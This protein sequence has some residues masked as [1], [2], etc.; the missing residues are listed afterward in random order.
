GANLVRTIA[1]VNAIARADIRALLI[2]MRRRGT[3]L[4]VVHGA[5]DRL[6]STER[7]QRHVDLNVFAG[8]YSVAGGHQQILLEPTRYVLLAHQALLALGLLPCAAAALLPQSTGS[9]ARCPT[10]KP[11]AAANFSVG[12][13]PNWALTSKCIQ[14]PRAKVPASFFG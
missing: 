3:A 14:F 4:A 1:E 7:L 9:P 11:T 13:V 12:S 6:F 8:Y 2:E 10:P 5:D